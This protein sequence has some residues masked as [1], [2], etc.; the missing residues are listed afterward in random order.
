M[1][2]TLELGISL[3][4]ERRHALHAI[5]CCEHQAECILFE[6]VCGVDV[7]ILALLH[8]PL[9]KCYGHRP[10]RGDGLRGLEGL[11]KQRVGLEDPIDEIDAKRIVGAQGLSGQDDLLRQATP[12]RRTRR[13]VPPKPGTRPR[14]TSG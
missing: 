5:L 6:R 10:A 2:S 12:T 9:G 13:L 1:L 14:F 4:E 11:R 8:D 7:G 3:F